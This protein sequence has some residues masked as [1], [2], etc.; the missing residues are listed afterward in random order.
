MK[1][2]MN[3]DFCFGNIGCLGFCSAFGNQGTTDV[4]P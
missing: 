2:E 1:I 4:A 3:F